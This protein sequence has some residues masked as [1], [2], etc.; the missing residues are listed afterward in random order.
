MTTSMSISRATTDDAPLIAPLFAAYREFYAK[1]DG[2]SVRCEVFLRERL[3]KRESVVFLARVPRDGRAV[4]A[5]FAQLYPTY[6]SVGL[7]RVWH[8]NDLFVLPEFRRRG[9]AKALT[10]HAIAFA[11][12]DGAARF[13]LETQHHNAGA[14]AL[15]EHL[16]MTLGSEFVKYAMRFD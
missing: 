7:A 13:T 15:Y 10:L 5:G 12:Q 4:V 6:T 14:R 9:V 1:P 8:M 2:D 11:R 16:G 3:S